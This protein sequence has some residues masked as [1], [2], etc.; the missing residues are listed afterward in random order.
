MKRGAKDRS[1]RREGEIR[2]LSGRE[3]LDAVAKGHI[4]IMFL[5][6]EKVVPAY[7]AL[8]DKIYGEIEDNVPDLRVLKKK[9]SILISP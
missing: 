4:W 2:N 7:G 9:I 5:N 1:S 3:V 6:P 8:L